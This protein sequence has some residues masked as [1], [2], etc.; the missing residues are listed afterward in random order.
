MK[1]AKDILG[2]IRAPFLI[3]PP[4][5][6]LLGLGTAVRAAGQVSAVY[7]F[8]VL[9]GAV[10]AHI[11]VNSLNEYFDFKSDLDGRTERTPFSGGSG[12]LPAK[13]G[14][15]RT[16]LVTGLFTLSLTSLIGIYFSF[17]RGIAFIP[18]GILGLFIIVAYTPWLTNQPF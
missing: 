16:A 10:S 9:I 11:S 1:T 17:V 4:V 15:A 3:L 12:V 8:L 6:V 7:F 13:P 18:L 14:M 2:V 5:C